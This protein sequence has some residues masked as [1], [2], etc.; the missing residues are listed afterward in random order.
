[1]SQSRLGSIMEVVVSTFVGLALSFSV[2]GYLY[3]LYG[4]EVQP[5]QNLQMTLWM[6]VLSVC[7]GYVLRRLFNGNFWSK[8]VK[9]VP[10][11][12]SAAMFRTESTP[13]GSVLFMHDKARK[14]LMRT[15]ITC[16]Y[17]TNGSSATLHGV[18]SPLQFIWW[19]L[20]GIVE[21]RNA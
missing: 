2:Q 11:N 4:I 15:R 7:R 5:L 21:A 1:M 13:G 19:S 3:V 9:P 10:F 17:A 18:A 16:E 6:T 14:R 12:V 8:L 20:L